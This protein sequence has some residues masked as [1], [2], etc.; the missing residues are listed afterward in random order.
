MNDKVK[1]S[2]TPIGEFK[3][4]QGGKYH[5]VTVQYMCGQFL[6]SDCDKAP[7]RCPDCNAPIL[8]YICVGDD[9]DD[10]DLSADC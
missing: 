3:P 5:S 1:T 9:D 10:Q 8:N 4:L 6:I 7:V 2:D